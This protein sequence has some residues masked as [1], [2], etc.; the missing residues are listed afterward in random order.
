MNVLVLSAHP[1]DE[2]LGA[3]ATLLGHRDRG[4]SIA[5]LVATRAYAPAWPVDVVAE[6]LREVERVAEAYGVREL[7]HLE[8]QAARLDTV[9]VAELMAPIRA[10]VERHRPEVVYLPHPGDIHTD[11]GALFEA[12]TA[13]VRA[14]RSVQDGLRRIACYETISSTDS[15]PPQRLPRFTANVFQDVTGL[16]E[17]KLEVMALYATE[18]QPDPLPRGPSA[19]AALARLRGA[20]V[21]VEHAEAFELVREVLR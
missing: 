3:G 2:T 5:W 8:H 1:D 7:V 16:L 12:A 17:R 21:G 20:T 4:D 14:F 11:H 15:A 10:L 6:K 13:S 18:Q 19:I 9:P